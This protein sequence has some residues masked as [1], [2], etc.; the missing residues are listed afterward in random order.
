VNGQERML[1]A[2]RGEP[3]DRLPWAPRMDLW[4]IGQMARGT[5]PERFKGM[6]TAQIAD[7][8]GVDCHAVRCDETM[9][10]NDRDPRDFVLRAF[11]LWNHIDFPY[12]VEVDLPFDF[13][14][15]P[16]GAGGGSF[17][18]YRTVI[19]APA[20][21]V[22]SLVE[23][24]PAMARDGATN[25][26]IKQVVVNGPEDYERIAQ[27]Y[28]H[29]VVVPT[30]D[31]YRSFHERI[32]TRGLALAQGPCSSSPVHA[33]LHMLMNMETFFLAYMDDAPALRRLGERMAPFFEAQLE[34]LAQSE[35]EV[36]WWG[37]NY[38]QSTTWPPF[39]ANEI[40]PY[41]RMVGDRLRAAGKFMASHCDG[42]NDKLLEYM[43]TARFDIAESVPTIPMVKRSLKELREGFGEPTTVWG[44]IA[45]VSLMDQAMSDGEFEKYIDLTFDELGSGK[46]LI[47]GV[48]DN[49]PVDAN[50][51]RIDRITERV[52]DFGPVIPS[53]DGSL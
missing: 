22:E 3:T 16:E 18:T 32:G 47:L 34:V 53:P 15:T 50:L 10:L 27:V 30:P 20:G 11:G 8:L 24:T 14:Y 37:A 41:V 48:S 26:A 2:I 23:L 36:V 9:T 17:G 44:G 31:A 43:P 29:F 40:V 5:L 39:F 51:D 4:A 12:R 13:T 45:A 25:P 46:R 7:E 35:A 33:I 52:R 28:E 42:E 49:V 19:H 38:D 6:N 21:D 1:A